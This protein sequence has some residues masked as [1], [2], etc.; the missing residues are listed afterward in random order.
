MFFCLEF[1]HSSGSCDIQS[2]SGPWD[3]STTGYLCFT[4]LLLIYLL[5]ILVLLY[6]Y[7]SIYLCIYL[8][9]IY[10]LFNILFSKPFLSHPLSHTVPDMQNPFYSI[11]VSS[12][13]CANCWISPAFK[14]N[15]IEGVEIWVHIILSDSQAKNIIF[16][17][18]EMR[19]MIRSAEN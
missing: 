18:V 7:F 15:L 19:R 1:L 12:V 11:R 13:H 9:L 16:P 10:L 5:F 8:L 14:T 4:L 3:C 2:I 17:R 6:S